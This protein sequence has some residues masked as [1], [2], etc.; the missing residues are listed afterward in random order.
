M[1]RIHEFEGHDTIDARTERIKRARACPVCEFLGVLRR[2]S[3]SQLG[4]RVFAVHPRCLHGTSTLYCEE[5]RSAS[6]ARLAGGTGNSGARVARERRT[7]QTYLEPLWKFGS[8]ARL[9]GK[10]FQCKNANQI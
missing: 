10:Q 1:V 9:N 2:V 5:I 7:V 4:L 6:S 8:E 3:F